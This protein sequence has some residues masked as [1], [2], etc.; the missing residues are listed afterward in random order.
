[1]FSCFCQL[2]EYLNLYFATHHLEL[3][4]EENNT[5][6]KVMRTGEEARYLSE[7]ECSLISF[8]YFMAT[9][10]DIDLKETI[11]WIDDPISSLDNNNIF[12]IF[13]LI[14]SELCRP[15]EKNEC[16]YKYQLKSKHVFIT[17]TL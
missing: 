12:F 11:I 15:N 10:K 4:A 17:K 5:A 14:D 2:N 1:M 6:F 8:C 16:K 3:V 13:G 7:G 9:L